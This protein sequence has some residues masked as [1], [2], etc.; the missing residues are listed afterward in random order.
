MVYAKPLWRTIVAHG[1]ALSLPSSLPPSLP[2]SLHP[3]SRVSSSPLWRIQESPVSENNYLNL[4]TQ[5]WH[6]ATLAST[7]GNARLPNYER[8][9][10]F[11]SCT[12]GYRPLLLTNDITDVCHPAH[13]IET[14]YLLTLFAVTPS[15][16][17]D[18]AKFRC[19]SWLNEYIGCICI[20][21]ENSG[22]DAAVIYFKLCSSG[23]CTGYP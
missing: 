6:V 10:Y 7:A 19:A 18:A 15:W 11:C 22:Q 1:L 13:D 21:R 4:S 2:P 16:Q 17:T 14:F 9:H 12:N 8:H 5:R 20:S 23:E 3:P